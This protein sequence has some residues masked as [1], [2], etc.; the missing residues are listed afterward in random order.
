MPNWDAIGRIQ[1]EARR[2]L[3]SDMDRSSRL[4]Q[5]SDQSGYMLLTRLKAL[6]ERVKVL[7]DES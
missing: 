1:E 7:E 2:A 6:E 3:E 4:Q 5:E